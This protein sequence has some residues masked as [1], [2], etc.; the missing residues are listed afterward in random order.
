M[1]TAR[2]AS[3][4]REPSQSGQARVPRN[5]PSS[6]RTAAESVSR[7]RRSRFGTM[8][9]KAWRLRCALPRESSKRK[10][11]CSLAAA[12]EQQ[13]AGRLG[14]ARSRALE[15]EVVMARERLDGLE[16]L[17]IAPIPAAD[18][19]AGERQVRVRDDAL[20]IKELLEAQAVA[21]RAGAGRIV[22]REHARL[23]RRYREAALRTGVAA[24]EQHRLP[25]AASSGKHHA[26]R[27]I[28][29][30][31]RRL[32]RF[33]QPLAR[34]PGARLKRSTTASMR[35]LAPRIERRR[36]VDLVHRAVDAHA[37]EALAGQLGEQL[38]VLAAAGPRSA[39]RAAAPLAGPARRPAPG[40]P[41]G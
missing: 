3:F 1:R 25:S 11:I 13:P 19:A 22:E 21:G 33:G 2:A 14:A 9:S 20:G 30:A 5:F 23:E 38:G 18:R 17:G 26:R 37:H 16:V 10:S 8:P 40:P 29:E 12:V 36:G 6:S 27:A 28:D 24:G 4:R 7:K 15:I 31:Q 32:E 39:G 35:V 34:P 41:S